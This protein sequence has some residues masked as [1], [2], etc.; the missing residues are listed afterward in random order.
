MPK[1]I[2]AVEMARAAGIEPKRFRAALRVASLPWHRHLM[3]WIAVEGS[4]EHRDMIAV[5]NSLMGGLAAPVSRNTS[6][7][8]RGRSVRADSDEHYIVDLCDRALGST[9]SRGHRFPF[10]LGD[11]DRNGT[12][13]SLPVDAFYPAHQLVIEYCERQ[14]SETVPF[15]DRR[16]T[17][18]G[19]S[20]GEQ[21]RL[22]DQRR[23]DMLPQHGLMLIE[24]HY[25][26]FNHSAAKRLLR[27]T[28]DAE[29][30]LSRLK[31]AGFL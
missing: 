1:S 18:S 29:I 31:T 21:R 23:R 15:F 14:H 24:F 5:L 10:L 17:V 7:A 13:R 26:D 6:P 25:S 30:I 19:I 11:P 2:T 16:A 27:D 9:A 28:A 8:P 3:P 22:Y 4:G 20:R 12:R